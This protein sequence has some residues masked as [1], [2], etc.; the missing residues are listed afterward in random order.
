MHDSPLCEEKHS[1]PDA[2]P[3]MTRPIITDEPSIIIVHR[4]S[5]HCSPKRCPKKIHF[6]SRVCQIEIF[7]VRQ[8]VI[9]GPAAIVARGTVMRLPGSQSHSRREI[10]G[11]NSWNTPKGDDAVRGRD[12]RGKQTAKASSLSETPSLIVG[13]ASR[14]LD[15]CLLF[16]LASLLTT[17]SSS[18]L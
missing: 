10:R 3:K 13:G 6:Q 4:L 12:R 9:T 5:S 8:A 17:T 7:I 18:S 16:S 11:R 15:A 2:I 14:R 1:S